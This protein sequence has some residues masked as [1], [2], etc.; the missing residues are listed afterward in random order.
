MPGLNKLIMLSVAVNDMAKSKQFYEQTLGFKVISDFGEGDRRWVSLELPE[1]GVRITLTTTHENMQPGTLKLYISSQDI[2]ASH[3]GL[4][5][6]G[7]SEISDD[8]YG[9][10]SGVRWFSIND[11]DGNNWLVVE[12]K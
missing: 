3:E 2:E 1:G 5:P 11:P 10:G 12:A 7:A 9:L 8:L 4:K 6:A